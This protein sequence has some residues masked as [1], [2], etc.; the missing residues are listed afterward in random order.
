[1]ATTALDKQAERY[2]PYLVEIRKR[3]LFVVSIFLVASALGFIY[4]ERIIKIVLKLFNFEGVNIVFTSPFQFIN[5]AIN[6]GL[7][8]GLLIV[9]P[10][11]IVQLLLFLKP[12]LKK[13]EYKLL[14]SLLPLS[15]GLFT[16]GFLFGIFV[17]RYVISI[18][19]ERSQ[20]FEIGNFLD[21]SLLLSQTLLTGVLMG[22]AFQFPIV[23]TVLVRL[24]VITQQTLKKQRVIAYA[25]AVVF[26]ALL[27]PTDLL[28]LALLTV[29][30]VILFEFTLLLNRA[31]SRP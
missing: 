3:L 13:S 21:I 26:A 31:L 14:I 19:F 27:P 1:M 4:Y 15:I 23:L 17:M 5:L 29:P 9:F 6:S 7:I 22:V 25:A 28:S 11:V 16:I 12:A 18:F 24:K 2:L 8:V 20:S 30:L 10:L